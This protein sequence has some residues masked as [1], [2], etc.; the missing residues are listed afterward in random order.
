[1]VASVAVIDPISSGR[2]YGIEAKAMGLRPIA[3][4][5]GTSLP[6]PLK[7]FASVES[8]D[9]IHHMNS[10]EE[11]AR[12]L[13]A[14]NVQAVVAGHHFGL[15]VVDTLANHLGLV[16]NPLGGVDARLNKLAM[17]RR[18]CERGV[19]ATPSKAICTKTV[20]DFESVGMTFPVVLKPSEG[21]GSLSVKIC[22]DMDELRSGLTTIESLDEVYAG[23]DG[24]SLVEEYIDGPEHFIITANYGDGSKQ[25]LCFAKYDKLQTRHRPSI[26]KNIYSLPIDSEEAQAAF[27]YICDINRALDVDYGIN[28]VEFKI[29][30]EGPRVIEQNNRLP[31]ANV[32]F[33]IERCTGVNCYQL[34]L[35]IFS[36]AVARQKPDIVYHKHFFICC[37]MNDVEGT[38][39][40]IHGLQS[41]T[42]LPGVI[43]V[44]LMTG[45]GQPAYETVDFI[46][47]W[48]FVYMVHED[49]VLLKRNAE[50]IHANFRLSVAPGSDGDAKP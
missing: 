31:G 41:A 22:R 44:D 17:K 33:L 49:A 35:N 43:G 27:R 38:V 2:R 13:R 4:L 11:T 37:L 28:D 7:R 3:V 18:L 29:T 26:Y 8:F 42:A 15:R 45:I 40:G 1:M 14:R 36:D 21:S 16:G 30:P 19:A 20:G 10:V 34:N 25:L 48:A 12:F 5:T 24:L 46:T 39:V 23:K 6:E 47:T 32:P 50:L 9:E